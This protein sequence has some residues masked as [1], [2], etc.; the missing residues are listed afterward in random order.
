MVLHRRAKFLSTPSGWRATCVLNSVA[1]DGKNFYPRPPGGGRLSVSLIIFLPFNFYPRPPGGGRR[2][3]HCRYPRQKEFL[4]TPS[5]WRA[6]KSYTMQQMQAVDF[7]PR[8]PGG[9]RHLREP[10]APRVCDFYPRPPGG[11]RLELEVPVPEIYDFYPRP[12]GG[13]RPML[14]RLLNKPPKNFYPRPPGGGR[15]V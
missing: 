12:P 13:G 3:T 8:P 15:Q 9:G 14:M 11:G 7:Y 1:V 2:Q 4:S 5:G 10:M 6:T